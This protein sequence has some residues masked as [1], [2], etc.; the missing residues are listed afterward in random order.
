[1]LENDDIFCHDGDDNN[2]DFL[3]KNEKMMCVILRSKMKNY[4]RMRKMFFD[5]DFD[6]VVKVIKMMKWKK[7][8]LID[9]DE[10]EEIL[11]DDDDIGMKSIDNDGD[12]GGEHSEYLDGENDDDDDNH[13][14]DRI[15]MV[16]HDDR[17]DDNLK[18]IF[19]DV[20]HVLKEW[21][22]HDSIFYHELRK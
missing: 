9:V 3:M 5:L 19:V 12:D 1:M 7:N 14:V 18:K 11:I 15:L 4:E 17:I 2:D 16:N 10:N 8:I 20:H 21:M 13:V 22:N 6:D